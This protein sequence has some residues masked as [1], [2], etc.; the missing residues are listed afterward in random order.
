[1][2]QVLG[3]V[4]QGLFCVMVL[5]GAFLLAAG[6]ADG[7]KEWIRHREDERW[8][9]HRVKYAPGVVKAPRVDLSTGGSPGWLASG[10][11]SFFNGMY[12]ADG[13]PSGHLLFNDGSSRLRWEDPKPTERRC[14]HCGRL[15]NPAYFTCQGC[16]APA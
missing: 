7:L 6:I 13:N 11:V 1:M 8:R 15:W 16:G 10:S 2:E 14:S 12:V 5:F 3:A 4:F 9:K